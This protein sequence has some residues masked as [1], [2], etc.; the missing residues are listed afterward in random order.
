MGVRGAVKFSLRT[1]GKMDDNR[2]EAFKLALVFRRYIRIHF[3]ENILRLKPKS[4][5]TRLIQ[6][7]NPDR[8]LVLSGALV[9]KYVTIEPLTNGFRVGFDTSKI[10]TDG[11]KKLRIPLGDLLR[12]LEE[13]GDIARGKNSDKFKAVARWMAIQLRRAGFPKAKS[14]KRVYKIPARPFFQRI[15]QKFIKDHRDP[16]RTFRVV[17]WKLYIYV[18]RSRDKNKGRPKSLG[19]GS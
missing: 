5:F 19:M 1:V 6:N 15:A 14:G 2:A 16:E 17:G 10:Y 11:P 12:H 9:Q 8:P 18:N 7:S 4:P 13:G 3:R